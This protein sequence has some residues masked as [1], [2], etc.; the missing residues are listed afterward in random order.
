VPFVQYNDVIQ[1][2]PPYAAD[3]AF[4]KRILPRAARRSEYLFDTQAFDTHLKLTSIDS[5]AISQQVLRCC[6]PWKRLDDLLPGPPSGGMLHDVEIQHPTTVVGED[7][8]NEQYFEAHRR[9]H[10]EID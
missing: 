2:I 10:K 8:Q 9:Y 4:H 3:H 7:Q 1:T 5:I 6:I